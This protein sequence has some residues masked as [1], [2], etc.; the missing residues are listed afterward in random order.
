MLTSKH[1]L[2]FL[3][4]QMAQLLYLSCL[5]LSYS[6][7]STE[8]LFSPTSHLSERCT[9]YPKLKSSY[10]TIGIHTTT[11]CSYHLPMDSYFHTYPQHCK[12]IF[13]DIGFRAFV[14]N[15]TY[16]ITFLDIFIKSRTGHFHLNELYSSSCSQFYKYAICFIFILLPNSCCLSR[17][18]HTLHVPLPYNPFLRYRLSLAQYH[19]WDQNFHL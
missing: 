6:W 9:I 13:L 1:S 7:S 10:S 14:Y 12:F 4:L 17:S 5:I 8:Y 15:Q 16:I 19:N 3:G 2:S 11:L 18:P